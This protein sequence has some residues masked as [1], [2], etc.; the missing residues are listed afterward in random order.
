M[1]VGRR[2]VA[3]ASVATAYA[4]HVYVL[5][6]HFR[7]PQTD[8]PS[9]PLPTHPHCRKVGVQ[10]SRSGYFSWVLVLSR[11]LPSHSSTSFFLSL[12][13]S[14]SFRSFHSSRIDSLDPPRPFQPSAEPHILLSHT[15]ALSFSC[16]RCA[17][18]RRAASH[19]TAPRRVPTTTL[20]YPRLSVHCSHSLSFAPTSYLFCSCY[21]LV[22]VPHS[23]LHPN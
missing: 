7:P 3:A 16:E 19:R 17:G 15:Y 1:V 23:A 12:S 20:V 21:S 10:R 8:R 14:R 5:Q 22:S 9:H 18:K 13:H 2:R 6:H 11:P 4:L